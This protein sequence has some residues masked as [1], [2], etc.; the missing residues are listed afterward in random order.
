[1]ASEKLKRQ[2]V[3]Q[4][5]ETAE[6][7]IASGATA[8]IAVPV[9]TGYDLIG[10]GGY[11]VKGTGAAGFIIPYAIQPGYMAVRNNGNA[12]AKIT[13]ECYLLLSPQ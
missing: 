3:K 10:Y 4:T 12:Q 11:Y 5:V 6:T 13:I 9:P 2:I 1:M 7:T 8:W